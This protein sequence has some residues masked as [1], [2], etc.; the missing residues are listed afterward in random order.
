MGVILFCLATRVNSVLED[1]WKRYFGHHQVDKKTYTMF[2][3]VRYQRSAPT[4]SYMTKK[5]RA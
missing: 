5:R 1:R 2:D 3:E 4:G